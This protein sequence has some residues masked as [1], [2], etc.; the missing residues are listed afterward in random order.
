MVDILTTFFSVENTKFIGT[1]RYEV[2]GNGSLAGAALALLDKT[3]APAYLDIIDRPR[4]VELNTTEWF[5]NY[6]QEAL[7]IPNLDDD[8]FPCPNR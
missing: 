4:I 2:I 7:A 3:A 1:E 5:T 6:F 8:D